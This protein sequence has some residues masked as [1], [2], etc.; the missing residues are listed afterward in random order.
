[1]TYIEKKAAD[2]TPGGYLGENPGYRI[3]LLVAH[4]RHFE[5]HVDQAAG[6]PKPTL[7]NH[8]ET[9]GFGRELTDE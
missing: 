5:T 8:E 2:I 4:Y 3:R 7:A 6:Y 1:M 9:A